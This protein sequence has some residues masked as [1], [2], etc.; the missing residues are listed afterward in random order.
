LWQYKLKFIIV[1]P[2][3]LRPYHIASGPAV[4]P[5]CSKILAPQLLW[6]HD[7]ESVAQCFSSSK[8]K[9]TKD[10]AEASFDEE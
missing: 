1:N 2:N 4:G 5:F 7:R 3:I 9:C 10:S 8:F 6:I